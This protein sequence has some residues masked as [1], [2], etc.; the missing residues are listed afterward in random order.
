M[1]RDVARASLYR[2]L[3]NLWVEDELTRAYLAELWN[4][5][6]IAYFIGGGNEGVQAIV[7]DAERSGY[8]NVFAIIDRDYRPTNRDVWTNPAKTFRTFVL[9]VHEIENYLL[10]GRALGD[11]SYNNLGHSSE[12]IEQLMIGQARRLCWWAACRVVVAELRRR[13]R[14]NFLTDPTFPPVEDEESA[15]RHVC[16]SEW[17]QRLASDTARTT[18]DEV[19]RLLTV[20][21]VEAET[22][23]A[24]E[25]WRREFAGKE[26]LRGTLS[27]IF[28]QQ[29]VSNVRS[30]RVELESDIAKDVARWQVENNC[31]P[32][33]L[34]LLRDALSQRIARAVSVR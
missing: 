24:N 16:E 2:G 17:F 32:P 26:I 19:R 12:D 9:P 15:N 21:H 28:D 1:P 3:I 5:P 25:R 7:H 31:I 6:E 23:L 14:G 27:R 30:S 20:A 34:M 8:P 33:D 13:F 18:L 29:R 4:D 10:D 22:W 11:S